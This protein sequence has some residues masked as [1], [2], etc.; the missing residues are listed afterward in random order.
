MDVTSPLETPLG[1]LAAQS[2]LETTLAD[3]LSRYPEIEGFL[4]GAGFSVCADQDALLE[5]GILLPLEEALDHRGICSDLFQII[6]EGALS[7]G[8][9]A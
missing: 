4:H 9:A 5:D 6:L 3:L 7:K 8:H 1:P 2:V